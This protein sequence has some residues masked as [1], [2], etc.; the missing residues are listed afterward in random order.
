MDLTLGAR[1][2]LYCSLSTFASDV[3]VAC[4]NTFKRTS[5]GQQLRDN[6]ITALIGIAVDSQCSTF[7]NAAECLDQISRRTFELSSA[8]ELA[9]FGKPTVTGT[10]HITKLARDLLSRTINDIEYQIRK[11]PGK[12][13]YDALQTVIS[14]LAGYIY[15]FFL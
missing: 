6:L 11:V 8:A 2:R 12:L 14:Q 7:A 15:L 1:K 9:S 3:L 10:L 13:S 4:W 5:G